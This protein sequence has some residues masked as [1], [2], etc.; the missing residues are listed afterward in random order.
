MLSEFVEIGIR[1]MEYRQYCAFSKVSAIRNPPI[2]KPIGVTTSNSLFLVVQG[3]LERKHSLVAGL[4]R[5]RR[6][7][8]WKNNQAI[9]WTP[10]TPGF[11][12]A[13]A[14][15]VTLRTPGL[16]GGIYWGA[17]LLKKLTNDITR[18]HS[19]LI[20]AF[21]DNYPKVEYAGPD[22]LKD[23]RIILNLIFAIPQVTIMQVFLSRL[24]KADIIF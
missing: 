10:R 6:R 21:M 19:F 14:E 13:S 3:V 15:A 18:K 24:S 17:A 9:C 23:T 7:R 8:R 4:L 16:P 12:S 1:Y 20:L 5:E 2:K 11:R 22:F